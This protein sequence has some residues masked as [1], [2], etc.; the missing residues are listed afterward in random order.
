VEKNETPSNTLPTRSEY[1][2]AIKALWKGGGTTQLIIDVCREDMATLE[3]AAALGERLARRAS[4]GSG[5]VNRDICREQLEAVR[6]SAALL[7]KNPKIEERVFDTF[8]CVFSDTFDCPQCSELNGIPTQ[9][10]D[11]LPVT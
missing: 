9:H 3:E 11:L 10:G 8:R 7:R 4:T 2:L 6:A 1:S 5:Y